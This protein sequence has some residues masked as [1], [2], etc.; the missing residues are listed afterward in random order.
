MT[1]SKKIKETNLLKGEEIHAW[2]YK[3]YINEGKLILMDTW[4]SW[5]EEKIAHWENL[6]LSVSNFF[7]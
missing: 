7:T 4:M 3:E 5:W 2:W 6:V 1:T